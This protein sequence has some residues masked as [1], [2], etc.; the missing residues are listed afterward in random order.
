MR[1]A[2]PQEGL[3]RY[4]EVLR[5]RRALVIAALMLTVAGA[6]LYLALASKTY[7][8][9]ADLLVTPAAESDELLGTL[10]VIR[11]T[12]DPARAVETAARLVTTID[13]AERAQ[14][15]LGEDIPPQDLL[16]EISVEPVAQSSV[17]AITAKGSSATQAA[18]RANAFANA[19]IDDRNEALDDQ[20]ER[21]LPGLRDAVADPETPPQTAES[22]QG[23][24]ARLQLLQSGGDPTIRTETEAIP[25]EG[26][27]WPRP[28]LTVVAAILV[29]LLLGL[30]AAFTAQ[31]LDPRLRREEQLRSRYSLPILTR[32]PRQTS[33]R[34]SGP[35]SPDALAPATAEAYRTLRATVDAAHHERGQSEAVLVT[36]SSPSEGKTTTALNLAVALSL[37]GNSVILIEGDLR[38]PVIADT[39]G[40]EPE[41]GLVSVLVGD[42]PLEYALTSTDVIGPNLRLLL[43]DSRGGW[44]ADLFSQPSAARLLHEARELADFV[45]VDSPPLTAVVDTLPLARAVDD[46]IVVVRFD[47]TRIDRL[48]EL[49]ELL[50]SNDV[51]PLGFAVVGSRRPDTGYYFMGGEAESDGAPESSPARS[52]AGA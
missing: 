20:I 37:A 48:N 31:A 18:D 32:I 6:I 47:V 49:A 8:A 30:L 13:V 16:N 38:R 50:A 40:L 41:T 7:E 26:A 25:P 22:I 19:V 29:G 17:V 5:E 34:R 11:D 4:V 21:I 15:E 9:E 1:P 28:L 27:T 43:A 39:L 46:V 44:T 52:A 24:I 36:G 35:L 14:E 3:A 42:A 23:D 45:I 51:N 2:A 12:S 33:R 10:G